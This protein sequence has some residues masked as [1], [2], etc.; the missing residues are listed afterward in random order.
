M[1]VALVELVLDAGELGLDGVLL[2]LDGGDL[3]VELVLAVLALLE[4]LLQVDRA[5]GLAH[6]ALEQHD[7]VVERLLL[8]LGDLG[9]EQAVLQA[10][11]PLREV[12]AAALQGPAVLL[13]LL[14]L[15]GRGG[16]LALASSMA[17]CSRSRRA[18]RSTRNSPS[19]SRSCWTSLISL[20]N[21]EWRLSP[22]PPCARRLNLNFSARMAFCVGNAVPSSR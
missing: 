2:L 4:L 1:V 13:Q 15:S 17:L 3:V 19:F 21:S 10:V 8:L 5:I 9:R 7:L 16:T 6:L 22:S 14:V 11:E 12:L 20:W 18:L